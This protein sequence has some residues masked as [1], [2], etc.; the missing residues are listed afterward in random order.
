[1]TTHY[2]PSTGFGGVTEAGRRLSQA[3]ADLVDVSVITSDASL[4]GRISLDHFRA[5]EQPHLQ[6]FA[7]PYTLSK[8]SAPSLS[9][10]TLIRKVVAASDVVHL[11]GIYTYPVTIAAWYAQRLKKPYL[12]A[13]R[14]GL[15]PHMFRIRRL[16]KMAGFVTYVRPI[17]QRAQF[18][19][20]TAE[21]EV[22]HARAFGIDEKVIVIPNGINTIDPKQLPAI[23]E[24]SRLWPAL[25][26]RRVV[27]FLSRLSPQKGLD[28]LIAAWAG[29]HEDHRDAV[30]VIAGPDYNGYARP[31]QQL[32]RDLQV[33]DSVL[34][35]GQVDDERKWS[36]YQRAALFVLPSYAENFG[37]VIAEALAFDMPV[38]TTT[39]TPWTMLEQFGCGIC[40]APQREPLEQALRTLLLL[41]DEQ[42][43]TMGK[44]AVRLRATLPTWQDGA[45]EF[46]KLYSKMISIHQ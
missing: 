31:V 3:L 33:Q 15:D 23:P 1:M 28:I 11:N 25:G 8:K 2:P 44:N 35:T 40:I 46:I 20:A 24:A 27:L 43:M 26:N 21:Q 13:L 30:L 45:R 36:L 29:I 41:S 12:A 39:A 5:V 16:K 18:I 37:N 34:F 38:I 42:L 14:N 32:V 4:G 22:E 17:L 19:H 6:V 7:Y 10:H 9:G